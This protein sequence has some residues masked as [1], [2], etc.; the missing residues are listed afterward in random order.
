MRRL[1]PRLW[2]ALLD[3]CGYVLPVVIL[4]RRRLSPLRFANY[5][6]IFPVWL[7]IM[8]YTGVILETRIWGELCTYTAVAATLLLEEHFSRVRDQLQARKAIE[9]SRRAA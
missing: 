7:A 1:T 8:F 9:L 3:I 6:Y 5:L 4:F 2:P